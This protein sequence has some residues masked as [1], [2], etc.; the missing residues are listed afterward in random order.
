MSVGKICNREVV[1]SE[2]HDSINEAVKLMREHHVGNVV[3]V[4]IRDGRSYPVGILTDRDI[5]IEII[6][7]GVNLEAV[8]AGDVMSYELI[9][10]RE[11]EDVID[12]IKRMRLKGIRR[13]PVV[14]RG[15]ALVGIIAADDII[16]LLAEQMKDLAALI[17]NEQKR[18]ISKRG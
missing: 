13:M 4:E 12:A 18:E 16:D 8:T 2:R 1:I 9:V 6:A 5:V 11:D 17:G 14:D 3:I 7:K 15:G 10:A